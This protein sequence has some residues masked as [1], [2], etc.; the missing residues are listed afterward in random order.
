M[1]IKKILFGISFSIF[2]S[3]GTYASL[4]GMDIT[5]SDAHWYVDS[6]PHSSYG[7]YAG[8]PVTPMISG[9]PPGNEFT[10]PCCAGGQ[11]QGLNMDVTSWSNTD[12]FV[13]GGVVPDDN[14]L[15]DDGNPVIFEFMA[16]NTGVD[17][18]DTVRLMIKNTDDV[19]G[20]QG[21]ALLNNAPQDAVALELAQLGLDDTITTFKWVLANSWQPGE[22]LDIK[23]QGAFGFK[24]YDAFAITAD[25]SANPIP[26]PGAVWLFGSALAGLGGMRKKK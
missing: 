25:L 13:L 3:N 5:T 10:S 12:V 6:F 22:I 17:S 9:T 23:F 11:G 24:S 8:N 16:Q 2:L 1:N 4:T 18:Y 15:H 21:N 14:R 7:Y 26:L 20:A 19:T